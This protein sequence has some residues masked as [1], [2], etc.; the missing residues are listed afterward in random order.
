MTHEKIT[1]K[2]EQF[3]NRV[4]K[5]G[6]DYITIMVEGI[7]C[8]YWGKPEDIPITE[9][10]VGNIVELEYKPGKFV[11]YVNVKV[12]SKNEPKA[13]QED[14]KQGIIDYIGEGKTF[15]EVITYLAIKNIEESEADAIIESMAKRGDIIE[16][17]DRIEVLK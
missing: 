17:V 11:G 6:R 3:A 15:T 16:R 7:F 8:F 9:D 5:N 12:I 4:S 1:G 13:I 2:L 14:L 10:N